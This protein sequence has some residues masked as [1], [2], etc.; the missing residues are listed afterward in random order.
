MGTSRNFS[1]LGELCFDGL[2]SNHAERILV[3]DEGQWLVATDIAVRQ[4]RWGITWEI[5]RIPTRQRLHR[6]GTGRGKVLGAIMEGREYIRP[7]TRKTP[8]KD[9]SIICLD[10]FYIWVPGY[11]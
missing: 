8:S 6:D 7:G 4:V 2:S 11:E 3:S 1:G 10:E 5:H 9:P